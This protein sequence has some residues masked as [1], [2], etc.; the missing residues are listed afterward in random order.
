VPGLLSSRR[1]TDEQRRGHDRHSPV[2]VLVVMAVL[3]LYIYLFTQASRSVGAPLP[4][5]MAWKLGWKNSQVF[6][7]DGNV[8]S[9]FQISMTDIIDRSD[10]ERLVFLAVVAAAFLSAYFL[11]LAHKQRSLVLWA[12]VGLV[13]LFG[14]ATTAALL[15]AH[16][17]VYLV[18][19]P[20]RRNLPIAAIAGIAAHLAFVRDANGSFQWIAATV[21]AIASTGT[22]RYAVL[23]LLDRPRMAAVAQP[24]VVHAA[25]VALCAGILIDAADGKAWEIPVGLLMFF[26]QWARVTMYYIDLRDGLVPDDLNLDRYL[27]VFVSPAAIPNWNWGVAIPQGFAHLDS[28]FLSRDKNAIVFGGLRLLGVALLYLICWDWLRTSVS[29]WMDGIGI[30]VYR[31]NTRFLVNHFV[32]GASV[33]TASVLLTTLFDL[34]RF[35]LFFGSVMHLKVGLWRLFGYDV[36]AY[37]DRPWKATNLVALWGRFAFHYR[38]FLVRAFYYPSFFRFFRHSPRMRVFFASL[39]AASVGNFIWHVSERAFFRDPDLGNLLYTASTWPYFVFL[40]LGIGGYQVFRM[41]YRQKRKPWTRDR[42]ILIDVLAAYCTLQYF[43]L[44]HVFMRPASGGDVWDLFR[45][46]LLGFGIEIP[47]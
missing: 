18:L 11:P 42:W 7:D 4:S 13:V 21:L 46:F 14:V 40:G 34:A 33:S 32:G 39:M 17:V 22:Y 10:D 38:E 31:C 2:T 3:M 26:W 30:P 20:A 27:A 47:R 15:F 28:G 8:N 19:H 29:D 41:L 44:I 43:G 5:E 24:V 36:A 6:D 25:I 37:Y 1:V 9:N 12:C 16:L 45:L 35:M 23:P